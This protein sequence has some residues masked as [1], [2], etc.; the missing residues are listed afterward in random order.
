MPWSERVVDGACFVFAVWAGR[1]G[2][3]ARH[4]DLAGV[5]ERARDR[6]VAA[7]AAIAA[8][9]A[10]A[11]GVP[12]DVARVYLDERIRYRL[13]APD[14]AGLERFLDLARSM[15]DVPGSEEPCST[16]G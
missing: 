4:P 16:S 14:R 7:S 9:H 15:V 3:V 2:R 12:E 1:A 13:A 5:L 8:E 11:A 6:G 10:P